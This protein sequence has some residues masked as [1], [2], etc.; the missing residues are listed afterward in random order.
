MPSSKTLI[1]DRYEV[2]SKP[3]GQ[4]GMQTVFS[5][6]DWAFDRIVALKSPHSDGAKKKFLRSA[7]ASAAIA[8]PNVAATLDYVSLGDKEYLIEEYVEGENLQQRLDRDFDYFDVHLACHVIHHI[9]RGLAACHHAN[10]IHRDLKPSNIMVSS[11]AGVTTVKITDF[12][13]SKMAEAEIKTAV[14][15]SSGLTG[16]KSSTL[17]G[18]FPYMAPEV[19]LNFSSSGKPADIWAIAAIF[20]HLLYGSPPFGIGISA[21]MKANNES[22]PYNVPHYA[23]KGQ[24]KDLFSAADALIKAG[25]QRDPLRRPNID[26]FVQHLSE[27]AYSDAPREYGQIKFAGKPFKNTGFITHQNSNRDSFYH[28]ESFCGRIPEIGQKVSFASFSGDPSPRAHP[29]LP[30]KATAIIY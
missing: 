23:G 11:N 5:A 1:A 20:Y 26:T 7:Q 3:I 28:F 25:L 4:G 24:F 16:S 19:A 12:G 30:L 2:S 29:V 15:S 27:I 10:I 6:H 18:A 14:D 8:H 17:Q 9:A 13:I 21:V 22:P